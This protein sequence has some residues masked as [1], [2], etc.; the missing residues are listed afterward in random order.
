MYGGRPSQIL[1]RRPI[2]S[3]KLKFSELVQHPSLN[4]AHSMSAREIQAGGGRSTITVLW[5]GGSWKLTVCALA[6]AHDVGVIGCPALSIRSWWPHFFVVPTQRLSSI[7]PCFEFF[8]VEIVNSSSLCCYQDLNK[9]YYIGETAL[10]FTVHRKLSLLLWVFVSLWH[11][12]GYIIRLR[13][14]VRAN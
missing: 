13:K 11:K 7:N 1:E 5:T 12:L 10:H 6:R 4:E 14:R 8:V 2:G 3:T 9:V